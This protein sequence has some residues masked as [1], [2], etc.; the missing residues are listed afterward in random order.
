MALFV[1]IIAIRVPQS[2]TDILSCPN[3]INYSFSS[4][5]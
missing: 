2:M 3:V 1:V 5:L 4:F